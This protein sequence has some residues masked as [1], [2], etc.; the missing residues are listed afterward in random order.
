MQGRITKVGSTVVSSSSSL[1]SNAQ[2]SFMKNPSLFYP[3]ISALKDSKDFSPEK[4]S[5]FNPKLKPYL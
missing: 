2:G 5:L 4:S 1:I 3:K